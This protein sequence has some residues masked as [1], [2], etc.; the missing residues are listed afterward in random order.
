[1]SPER[2]VWVNDAHL[3]S[4]IEN[5]LANGTGQADLSNGNVVRIK[6]S[7]SDHPALLLDLGRELQ[8]G[9]QIVTGFSSEKEITVR[10][11][12]G[13]S[14]SEAMSEV[15]EES[16]ATNDHAMRDYTIKLPWLGN[17][18]IGNSGFRFVRI[19]V[20]DDNVELQ[21]KEVRAISVFRDIPYKGSFRCSDERLDRIWETGAYTVHLNMQEYLWDGIKRDRLVWIGDMYPEVMTINAVFGYNEV[22]PKTL[23]FARDITPLPAWMNGFSSYSISWLMIH[24]D[25]FRHNGNLEYLNDNK[26]YITG[27]LR[28]LISYIGPD[29]VER[30]GGI[31]F[32]DWPSS[33]NKAAVDAGLQAFCILAMEAGKEIC[34]ALGENVLASECADAKSRLV[35]ASAIACK[36]FSGSSL[37]Q[38]APGQKQAAALMSLSGL[39]DSK[40]ADKEYISYNGSH[41]FSTFFGF[42]MLEAMALAGNYAGAMDI[43]KEYWGA[44]IDLGATTFWEDFDI[45]WIENAAPITEPVPE[46]KI[47]VHGSYGAYCYKKFRHSLCHGWASGPTYWLSRHVLGIYPA[48]P[49]FKKVIISPNLGN[50]DWAEGS[51]PTPY[52]E[53]KVRHEKR[54]NGSIKSM[55]DL[56]EGVKMVRGY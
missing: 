21:L 10:I 22:V 5:L 7:E 31:R 28:Q 49:G 45:D 51:Y 9:L 15:G 39:M 38:D 6:T 18:E 34:I 20:L 33:E 26:E 14:V 1:M 35:S 2:I 41:G 16:G 43:I 52:G 42:F 56:P 17:L 27:L 55:I 47:D 54:K 11:R 32:L 23:D 4:G 46:G 13:E 48:E 25:W 44:M 12:L 29:G 19:D 8:G 37:P 30:L 53:I 24:Y 50:L 36:D 3:I 40:I